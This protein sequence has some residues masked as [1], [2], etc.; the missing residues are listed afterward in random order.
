MV[1]S[2]PGYGEV[3]FPHCA[4]DSRKYGR[5]IISVGAPSLKLYACTEDGVLQVICYGIRLKI[6]KQNTLKSRLC[7]KCVKPAIYRC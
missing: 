4:C 7:N 2:L 3:V 6:L 5:V 1:R